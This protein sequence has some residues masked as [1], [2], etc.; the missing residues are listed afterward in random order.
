MRTK[1]FHAKSS[2]PVA[3]PQSHADRV[4]VLDTLER[5]ARLYTGLIEILFR[6]RF[7]RTGLSPYSVEHLTDSKLS[8]WLVGLS[9]RQFATM[10]EF[11][12]TG[13]Q[14]LVVIPGRRRPDLDGE[15]RAVLLGETEVSS[16]ALSQPALA[17]GARTAKGDPVTYDN[18]GGALDLVDVQRLQIELGWQIGGIGTKRYY[19]S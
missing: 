13:T 2:R 5:Y 18:L 1:L 15:G 4:H 16:L 19:E 10:K 6:A 3:L 9:D 14:H 12:R 7:L 11:E 17:V 8:N